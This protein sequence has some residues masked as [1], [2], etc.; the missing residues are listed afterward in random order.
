MEWI[1]VNAELPPLH[2]IS[3]FEDCCGDIMLSSPV[4]VYTDEE[5]YAIARLVQQL[6][7]DGE[8]WGDPYW[9]D[10]CD[11]TNGSSIDEH[12]L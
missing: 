4:L 8:P 12:V 6:K 11:K 3:P 10:E 2:D 1:D 7:F 9:C 5:K